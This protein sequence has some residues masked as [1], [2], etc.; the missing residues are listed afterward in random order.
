MELNTYKYDIKFIKSLFTINTPFIFIY[1]VFFHLILI[2]KEN[3]LI[4]Q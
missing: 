1:K 3:W 4:I 2:L